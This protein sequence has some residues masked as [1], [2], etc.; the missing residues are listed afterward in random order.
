[1]E[2]G[3]L[4]STISLS[5]LVKIDYGSSTVWVSVRIH[6]FSVLDPGY[7]RLSVSRKLHAVWNMELME[8]GG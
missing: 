4:T 1:M 3:G 2:P 7:C 6:G 8:L 5:K